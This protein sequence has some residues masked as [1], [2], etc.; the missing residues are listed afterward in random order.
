MD[1]EKAFDRVKVLW[2]AMRKLGLEE[3]I[4]KLVQAMYDRTKSWVR[5]NNSLGEP[6][7]VKVGCIRD[8]YL[9]LS[10]SL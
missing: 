10:F 9:V 4:V 3:W 2:W 1:L 6:F 7:E 8:Q 5:V